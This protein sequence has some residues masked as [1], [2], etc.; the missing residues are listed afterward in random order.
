MPSLHTREVD[1]TIP[2]WIVR[3]ICETEPQRYRDG[4][5]SVL[6]LAASIFPAREYGNLKFRNFSAVTVS[7]E[8]EVIKQCQY[9][10]KNIEIYAKPSIFIKF[11]L[12]SNRNF[13]SVDMRQNFDSECTKSKLCFQNFWGENPPRPSS[14]GFTP[15]SFV[16]T[17][18]ARRYQ[19]LDSSVDHASLNP[20]VEKTFP[21]HCITPLVLTDDLTSRQSGMFPLVQTSDACT[22]INAE[23]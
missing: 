13:A 12:S 14:K 15:R 18:C 4:A 19:L 16:A 10:R 5:N 21:R 2:T 23:S 1:N 3:D 6:L 7:H 8:L 20:P 9:L 17:G 11:H 22:I